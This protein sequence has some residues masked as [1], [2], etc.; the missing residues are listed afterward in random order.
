MK[1]TWNKFTKNTNK[2]TGAIGDWFQSRWPFNIR[3]KQQTRR[4]RIIRW[5]VISFVVVLALFSYFTNPFVR[6]SLVFDPHNQILM[7]E[8][9][10]DLQLTDDLILRDDAFFSNVAFAKSGWHIFSS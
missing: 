3:K 5:S 8:G 9:Q 10:F 1:K 2:V 7:S 6:F 4:E